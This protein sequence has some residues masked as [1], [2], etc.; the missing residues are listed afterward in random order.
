MSN[1]NGESDPREID[2]DATAQGCPYAVLAVA[3]SASLDDINARYKHLSKAFH[4]DK[5]Q[6]P[7]RREEAQATFVEFK[8]AHDILVD[9]VLRQAYDDH[10]NYGVYFVKR[11]MNSSDPNSTF[12]QLVRLHKV[13]KRKEAKQ[14]LDEAIQFNEYQHMS[15]EIDASGSIELGCS[16]LHTAFLNEGAEPM[17]LPEVEKAAM[18]FSVGTVHG[19]DSKWSTTFGGSTHMRHGQAGGSGSISV[20][21]TPVQ[22]TD[23]SVDVECGENAKVSLSTSRVL[24]SQTLVTSSISTLPGS[25]KLALSLSSHRPLFRNKLRGTWAIGLSSPDFSL[26]Y[27]LL[28]FTS[29]Q[30]KPRYTAKLNIGVDP[31]PFRLAADHDFSKTHSGKLSYGWGPKGIE[32]SGIMTRVLSKYAKFSV[33]IKHVATK[34]L[35]WLLK[36]ER[37]QLTFSVPV[38]I[39]S[40]TSP[41]YHFKCMYMTFLSLLIDEAIGDWVF[42]MILKEDD[43]VKENKDALRR[44]E[45]HLAEMNK[46]R[47]DAQHQ[48][49]LMKGP[50][51][52]KREAEEKKGGLVIL[53]ATYEV[54]EGDSL[55]VS[56]QLQFWVSNSSTLVLPATSFCNLLGFYDIRQ[57]LPKDELKTVA[58]SGWRRALSRFTP[59]D[60]DGGPVPTLTIRYKHSGAVYEICVPDEDPLSLPS[61][62]ALKL[63]DSR[64]VK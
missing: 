6:D 62:L 61:A 4:P 38:S 44:E 21:Y 60:I 16:M 15:S 14:V 59:S 20:G 10:G 23:M 25:D 13:L 33:G 58:T 57:S 64:F 37:G 22:G 32:L 27:G 9:P 41:G 31:F 17:G 43:D 40:I 42:G 8:V 63:G 45:V 39:S 52:Q 36:I 46:A 47:T 48:C 49:A 1:S 53:S 19:N 2:D 51:N 7:A 26:H 12:R 34:G 30:T 11:S 24:L 50:A 18:N 55:D 35:T 5:Q 54:E 29:L 56:T 3:Q 28:Q